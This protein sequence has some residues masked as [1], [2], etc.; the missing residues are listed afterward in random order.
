MK[1]VVITISS[2]LIAIL[3]VISC[4]GEIA[5]TVTVTETVTGTVTIMATSG[6]LEVT[7]FELM[8]TYNSAVLLLEEYAISV[9]IKLGISDDFR[10]IELVK[11]DPRFL[12]IT[13]KLKECIPDRIAP[14]YEVKDGILLTENPTP[15]EISFGSTSKQLDF[16]LTQNPYNI[17]FHITDTRAVYKG[18]LVYIWAPHNGVD[19][20]GIISSLYIPE[21][22]AI[23]IASS[24]VPPNYQLQ[25]KEQANAYFNARPYQNDVWTVYIPKLNITREELEQFGWQEGD[26]VSFGNT[27]PGTNEYYGVLVYI[28]GKTGEIISKTTGLWLGPG[29]SVV[30]KT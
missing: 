23:E 17:T 20:T 14:R 10:R 27:T 21:N 13:Q 25:A 15:L 12:E 11:D 5:E 16:T 1:K 18:E 2:V 9:N 28:D 29:P 3:L 26:D 7:H 8:D 19:F 4:S 6:L 22:Q 30:S 24:Q